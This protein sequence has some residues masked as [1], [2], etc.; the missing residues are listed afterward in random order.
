MLS[1]RITNS[2]RASTHSQQALTSEL[3]L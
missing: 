2:R 3:L 1:P